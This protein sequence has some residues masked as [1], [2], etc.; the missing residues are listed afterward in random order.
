MEYSLSKF[1]DS[2]V[3]VTPHFT[4]ELMTRS[5]AIAFGHWSFSIEQKEIKYGMSHLDSV[6]NTVYFNSL[7]II[8]DLGNETKNLFLS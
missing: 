1:D 5:E 6:H 7:G 2:Y 3:W 4:Y 8:E